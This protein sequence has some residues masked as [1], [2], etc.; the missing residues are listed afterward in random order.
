MLA[1]IGQA[2][3]DADL[4]RAFQQRFVDERRAL[5]S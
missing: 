2:Q 1:L 5:K 4:A 3:H